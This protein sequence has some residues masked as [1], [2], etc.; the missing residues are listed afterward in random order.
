MKKKNYAISQIAFK[1]LIRKDNEILFLKLSEKKCRYDLPGG[2][3]DRNENLVPIKKILAREIKEE[4]GLNIKYKIGKIAFQYRR[5]T[6]T[7]GIY[8]L[9]TVYEGKY[10]SGKIKLSHEHCDYAWLDPEKFRFE[11]DCFTNQEEILAYKEYLGI[12]I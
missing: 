11:K 1:I 7:K 10:L 6:K 12:K 5:K 4:L 2:R 3:A 8:N 9:I